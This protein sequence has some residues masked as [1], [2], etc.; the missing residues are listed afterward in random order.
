M[1]IPTRI[2]ARLERMASG[3]LQ[4]TG[5]TNEKGY[6]I[7]SWHG[8]RR[9][10]HRVLFELAHGRAPRTGLELLHAC[11]NRRCANPEHLTEGT[12]RENVQDRH[13]KGRTRGCCANRRAA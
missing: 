5:P 2:A 8:Q 13:Q 6:G 9:R 4:W 7:V 3:C 11:D 12:T 10:V 1:I